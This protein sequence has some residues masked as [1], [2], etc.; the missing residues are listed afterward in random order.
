MFG[1]IG[2]TATVGVVRYFFEK[3][4]KNSDEKLKAT[5]A[6][7]VRE[8]S[9]SDHEKFSAPKQ[10]KTKNEFRH[11]ISGFEK[12]E[13]ELKEKISKSSATNRIINSD[14]HLDVDLVQSKLT[15]NKVD[16]CDHTKDVK[17]PKVVWNDQHFVEG[18]LPVR[19]LNETGSPVQSFI[20][21]TYLNQTDTN[22][23][24][25]SH[26]KIYDIYDSRERSHDD[27]DSTVQSSI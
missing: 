23:A 1:V 13:S 10:Q 24:N 3:M 9:T 26:E 2:L 8:K 27:I 15:R 12:H 19:Y 14:K 18:S 5:P 6:N 7:K 4:N 17:A 11:N 20:K 25:G 21:N 16:V 22:K